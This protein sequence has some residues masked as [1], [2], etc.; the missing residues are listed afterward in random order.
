MFALMAMTF[1]ELERGEAEHV[2]CD[3]VDV[4]HEVSQTCTV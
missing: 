4:K 3:T 1:E 2:V